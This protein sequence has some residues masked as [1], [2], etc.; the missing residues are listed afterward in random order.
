MKK[1]LIIAVAML[2]CTGL[3]LHAAG[4]DKLGAYIGWP[5]GLS[6]SHEFNNYVELDLLVGISGFGLGLPDWFSRGGLAIQLGPLFTV[7]DTKIDG[8]PCPFVIGP[9]F[10]ITVDPWDGWYPALDVLCAFRWEF[11][12]KTVKHFNIFLEYAP[13]LTAYLY[14]RGASGISDQFSFAS[15]AGLGLRYAW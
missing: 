4:R 3:V 9:V 12:P 5:V 14:D 8:T 10:G 15:R 2:L 7:T 11:F 13:G 6:Y 1:V